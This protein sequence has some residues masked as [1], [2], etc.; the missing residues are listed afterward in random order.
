MAGTFSA[1]T[2]YNVTA[3]TAALSNPGLNGRTLNALRI[4]GANTDVTFAT[5]GGNQ[6][7]LTS[8]N[9]LSTAAGQTI[10]NVSLVGLS[11]APVLN[12]GAVEG[13]LLVDTGADLTVNAALA[14][15]TNMTK[16]LS[17]NLTFAT[18]QFFNSGA[19]YFTINGGTVT[20]AGVKIPSGRV[21]KAAPPVSTSRSGPGPRSTSVPMPRWWAKSNHLMV[22]PLLLP[23][24]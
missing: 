20:L 13:G 7:T 15:S 16:G 12:F 17:G 19:S 18:K 9:L 14:G 3:D 2:T 11:S 23:V 5:S 1:T 21:R 6:L 4:A 10:G 8:G 22:R 24:A